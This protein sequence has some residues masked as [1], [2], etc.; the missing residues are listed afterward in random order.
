MEVH[1]LD[2][3]VSTSPLL[4][5][6]PTVTTIGRLV[7]IKL[8]D[9]SLKEN[10]T[11]R[12]ALGNA[13]TD[14]REQTPYK[15]F[16]YTFS[17]GNYFDSLRLKGIVMD[18]AT[19]LPDSTATIF[20]YPSDKSD[21]D[22]YRERPDYI[23]KVSTDGSFSFEGL[24]DKSFKIF[25][26]SDDDHNY[27]YTPGQ[28][29]IDFYDH[30]VTPAAH[31]DSSLIFS[32]FQEKVADSTKQ[33][34]TKPTVQNRFENRKN[35]SEKQHQPG[36]QVMVDTV[37]K[38]GTFDLA[39]P[40]KIESNEINHIDSSH[41]YLSYDDKGIDVEAIHTLNKDS[42]AILINTQWLPEKTYTLRL[43]KG[44]ATDTSGQELSPGKYIFHTR[45][46]TDYAT[47]NINVDPSYVGAEYLLLLLNEGKIVWE[48]KVLSTK[49]NITLLKPGNY[50]LR[51]II[52]TNEDGQW[53]TGNLLK[54]NHAEKV[55]PYPG[56]IMLK[57]GW[58]NDIDFKPAPP[59]N[60]K[61]EKRFSQ[62]KEENKQDEHSEISKPKQ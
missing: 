43:I 52:D 30:L 23:S 55:L 26:V 33:T 44:W 42:A 46:L 11:Y 31:P 2:K 9:S 12:I 19:G 20:L 22:V 15:N 35:K 50:T 53:N 47:L 24:P 10:T 14:N 25:A 59:E 57:A 51:L 56:K 61:K 62:N 32:I 36:Y 21:T 54:Q 5:T 37:S 34:P 39:Q 18:A 16:V 8:P 28:E 40:L 6:P 27:I 45:S 58:I 1:N 3:N 38:I 29:K 48:K 13:L 60:D 17:T 7:E 41:I 49:L 4:P